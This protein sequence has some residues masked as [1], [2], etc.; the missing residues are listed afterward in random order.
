MIVEGTSDIM[1]LFIAREAVDP[2][3]EMAGALVDPNKTL[4]EKLAALPEIIA[5]YALWYPDAL[6]WLWSVAQVPQGRSAGSAPAVLRSHDATPGTRRVPRHAGARP[7]LE[8]R[9]AFL[10]RL[11]D[12]ANELFAITAAIARAERMRLSHDPSAESARELTHAFCQTSRRRIRAR[13]AAL[14]R[15]DDRAQYALAQSTLAGRHA[16]LEHT[17]PAVDSPKRLARPTDRAQRR[18]A[19]PSGVGFAAAAS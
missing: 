17:S 15:N 10:F 19:E 13:F 14:W 9:Q 11:V 7:Q 1:H 8:K 16:W 5:F 6:A 18:Q 4:G 2:H 3:L 12:I